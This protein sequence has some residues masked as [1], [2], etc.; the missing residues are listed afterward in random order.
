MLTVSEIKMVNFD[1]LDSAD[2][3]ASM[4]DECDIWTQFNDLAP[5]P[6]PVFG[7][8]WVRIQSVSKIFSLSHARVMLIN[9]PFTFH[10]RAQNSPSLFHLSLPTMNSTVVILAVRRTRV[11]YELSLM[12]LLPKSSCSSVDR[13]P[14]RCSG[15]HGFE[16]YRGLSHSVFLSCWLIHLLQYH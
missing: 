13:E 2:P 16:S 3:S 15:G 12:I 8:S 4:H 14:A 5:L 1:E 9:S 11:T 7:R 6:S 10:Y